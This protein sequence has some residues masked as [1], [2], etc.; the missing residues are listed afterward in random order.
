MH[1]SFEYVIEILP[2]LLKGALV[3]IKITIL[4]MFIANL[5]GLVLSAIRWVGVKG[6]TKVF[7]A[8][9]TIVRNVPFIVFA[10][11]G[12][13]T[14]P[15]IGITFEPMGLGILILSLY[16]GAFIAEVYRG[17]ILAVDKGQLEAAKILNLSKWKT[18]GVVILPQ[19]F[20][21]SL[22]SLVNTL[23]STF[24]DSAY[25]G[26]ITVRELLWYAKNEG[27]IS[28]R[29]FEPFLLATLLYF[30]ISYPVALLGRAI[31]K[32]IA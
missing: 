19:I 29:M 3:T 17:S 15:S 2:I 26:W 6:V 25:L 9:V 16:S 11:Y 32:K 1:F 20:A 21:I 7:D 8:Y 30:V 14:L 13:Y 18:M 12:Y 5:W 10:F 22:P 23:I 28:F 31:E 4:A 27:S 24:K